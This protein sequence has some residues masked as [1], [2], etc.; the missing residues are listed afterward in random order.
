MRRLHH[1]ASPQDDT[2]LLDDGFRLAP[3]AQLNPFAERPSSSVGAAAAANFVE[4]GEGGV[5]RVVEG[6]E[7]ALGGGDGSVTE[8]F[9]DDLKV[10]AAGQE[11]GCVGVAEVVDADLGVQVGFQGGLPDP[12]AEPVGG[13]VAVGLPA[14]GFARVVLA[15]DAAAGPVFLVDQDVGEA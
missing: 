13:D 3:P 7:V 9:L 2:D 6:V 1:P 15:V 5:V 4:G 10:G 14:A 11:P 8:A 12:V